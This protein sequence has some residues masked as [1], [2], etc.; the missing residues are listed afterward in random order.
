MIYVRECW[1]NKKQR[2]HLKCFDCKSLQ[3]WFLP[4]KIKCQ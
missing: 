4:V 2:E 3:K 1:T